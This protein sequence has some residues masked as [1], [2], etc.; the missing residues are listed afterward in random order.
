[1]RDFEYASISSISCKV[2]VT[3]DFEMKRV[4]ALQ[5]DLLMTWE[6]TR[7]AEPNP[8]PACSTS[9]PLD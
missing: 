5:E 9:T 1:M 7:P 2:K 3:S 6:G 8:P 4:G